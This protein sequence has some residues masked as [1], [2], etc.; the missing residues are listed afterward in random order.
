MARPGLQVHPKF[1]RL[2]HAL[3]EPVPHVL[4]YLECMWLVGYE[5]GNPVLGDQVDVELASQY[6]GTAGRL[7]QALLDCKFIDAM[8][9]GRY[10]IHDLPE[11]APSYVESHPRREEE[12]KKVKNCRRCGVEFHSPETRAKFCSPACRQASY[13]GRSQ[14]AL[15][16]RDEGVRNSDAPARNSDAPGDGALRTV[17]EGNEPPT[18]PPASALTDSPGGNLPRIRTSR[19]SSRSSRTRW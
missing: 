6:P 15:T 18:P 2:V 1:R 12:R 17:T 10:Q 7:C 9:D 16:Q 14:E 3:G 8:P 13:R 19:H 11:N 5:S 4:G